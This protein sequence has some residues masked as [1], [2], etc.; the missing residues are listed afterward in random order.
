MEGRI[1]REEGAGGCPGTAEVF[2]EQMRSELC[3][4]GKCWGAGEAQKVKSALLHGGSWTSPGALVLHAG[5]R[6]S[7]KFQ[8]GDKHD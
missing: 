6:A 2:I 1:L 5:R 3:A 4:E 7:D 8:P